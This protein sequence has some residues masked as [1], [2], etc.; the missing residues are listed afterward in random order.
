M[1][2]GST[3]AIAIGMPC[4]HARRKSL[5]TRVLTRTPLGTPLFAEWRL[6]TVVVGSR[7]ER[8]ER[9]N[10]G[11]GTYDAPASLPMN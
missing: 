2:G 1:P 7:F 9:D 10:R 11:C 4:G 8:G 3:R 6:E 5:N